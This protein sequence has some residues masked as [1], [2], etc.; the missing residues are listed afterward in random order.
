MPTISIATDPTAFVALIMLF[1][2]PLLSKLTAQG[3]YLSLLVNSGT[4]DM[5]RFRSISNKYCYV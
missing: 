3:T 1:M 5:L 4:F 2:K